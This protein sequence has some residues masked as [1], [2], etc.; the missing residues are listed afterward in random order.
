MSS[1]TEQDKRLAAFRITA[2]DLRLLRGLAPFARDRLPALLVELHREFAHWPEIQ[3][4]L[5]RP[6]VHRARVSHWCRVVSGDV[7]P[8]FLESADTL[9]S[10]FYAHGVPGYAVAICHA[11]VMHGILADLGLEDAGAGR[12]WLGGARRR[13]DAAIRAALNKGA[14]FD[15][16]LL[17]ETY[18]AAER[19]SRASA[20]TGMAEAIE[21]EAGD[22]MEQVST[23]TSGMSGTAQAMSAT[24]ARTGHDADQA[25][26]AALQTR[27]TAESMARAAEALT[28][29]INGIVRQV[30]DSSACAQR[31]VVAG[32]G[33]RG[34][35]EAMSRQ[36]EEI[37]KVADLIADIAARTNLLA[38]NATIEAARAGEAGKGFAV[39]ASEVKQLATQTAHSTAA[40]ARQIAAVRQATANAA[41][42]VGQMVGLIGEIDATIAAVAGAVQEQGHATAAIGRSVLD[43]AGAATRMTALTEDV[44]AAAGEADAQSGEVHRTAG[45]LEGA[46][47]K[48]RQ[49]V[50]RVVRTSTQEVDRRRDERVDC[51][52]PAELDMGRGMRG[53]R[54]L[55]LSVSGALVA[56][57]ESVARD[58]AGQL[59]LAGM[60]IPVA[61]VTMRDGH[62]VLRLMLEDGQVQQVLGLMRQA[63]ARA[64]KAA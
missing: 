39:V 44:R 21:R 40:I 56:G 7:G 35:I 46:V 57:V 63:K 49:T 55:N 43:T 1:D 3:N 19:A 10:L 52:L 15:L 50:I 4:A 13:Q 14:W 53:V 27:E 47:R 12:G 24:A 45:V 58:Q 25:A 41:E 62:A 11:S 48:L 22:A 64:R 2:E 61:G 18:A 17:L 37:G 42:E 28:L 29:S 59:L 32:Q 16:E 23:L 33:A 60:R 8:G 51:D 54:V 36:A 9:A 38:L 6:E 26:A 34:S 5:A 31:A 30:G 20:L